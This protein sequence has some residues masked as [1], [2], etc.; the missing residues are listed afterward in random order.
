MKVD[1]TGGSSPIRRT[2][3]TQSKKTDKSDTK[4]KALAASLE[5]SVNFEGELGGSDL[6]PMGTLTTLKEKKALAGALGKAK[7]GSQHRQ[8]QA[9]SQKTG[10]RAPSSGSQVVSPTQAGL[11]NAQPGAGNRAIAAV[12]S[13]RILGK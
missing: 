6:N 1:S 11:I 8:L 9:N 13:S 5:N 4:S 12:F 3:P 10:L 7:P 2:E